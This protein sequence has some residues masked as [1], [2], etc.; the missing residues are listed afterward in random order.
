MVNIDDIQIKDNFLDESEV[1]QLYAHFLSQ[2][3]TVRHRSHGIKQSVHKA[4]IAHFLE[5]SELEIPAI[6]KVIDSLEDLG[7]IV[8]IYV[9]CYNSSTEPIMHTDN[10][11]KTSMTFIHPEYDVDWGGEFILYGGETTGIAVQPLPGR[12]VKFNGSALAHTGRPFNSRS[13]TNRWILVINYYSKKR[14]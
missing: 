14:Q 10:G 9:Q 4:Q 3:F 7:K 11:D 12:N 13:K 2:P 8:K 1:K 5:D 6:K